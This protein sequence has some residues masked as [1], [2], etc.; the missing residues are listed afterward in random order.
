MP[1]R[2]G[3]PLKAHISIGSNMFRAFEYLLTSLTELILGNIFNFYLHALTFPQPKQ[4]KQTTDIL[5]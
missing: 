4:K 5:G 2:I 1:E 3:L